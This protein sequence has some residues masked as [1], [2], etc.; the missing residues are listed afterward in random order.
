MESPE[1]LEFSP[2]RPRDGNNY[3]TTQPG[4]SSASLISPTDFDDDENLR[5]TNGKHVQHGFGWREH[6]HENPETIPTPRIRKRLSKYT[7]THSPLNK[8]GNTL[9]SVSRNIK[10]MSIRVVNLAGLG[11]DEHIR[12]ADEGDEKYSTHRMDGGAA[13]GDY[14]HEHEG[15]PD[16]RKS[17]LIRG[18]SLGFMGPTNRFRL[19]MYHFLLYP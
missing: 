3:L 2:T 14:E 11:L 7:S 10:R 13:E 16:L 9:R 1:D 4:P 15:L 8:T 19:A 6:N 5:L 18:R 17:L 12:L